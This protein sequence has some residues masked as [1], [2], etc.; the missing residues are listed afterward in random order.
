MGSGY[1]IISGV[2]LVAV[3]WREDTREEAFRKKWDLPSNWLEI[4]P[5]EVWKAEKDKIKFYDPRD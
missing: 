3:S 2:F 4:K 5:F 1:G